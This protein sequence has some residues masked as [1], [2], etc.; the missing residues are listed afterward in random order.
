MARGPIIKHYLRT[1][2]LV[3]LL[4]TLPYSWFTKDRDIDYWPN[5]DFDEI[6]AMKYS[7]PTELFSL[8]SFNVDSSK[9]SSELSDFDLA[10]TVRLM[11]L[12]RVVKFIKIN[13]IFKLR[14][15]IYRVSILI[16]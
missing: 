8:N 16:L 9:F 6:G 2:F 5:D 14:K 15:L 12:I 1:W 7:L 4:A 3:D 11:K 10:Q 13:Q